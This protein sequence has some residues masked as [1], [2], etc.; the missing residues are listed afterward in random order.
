[1]RES[2]SG[3][4]RRNLVASVLVVVERECDLDAAVERYLSRVSFVMAALPNAAAAAA[5][6]IVFD[7]VVVPP[8]VELAA[9]LPARCLRFDLDDPVAVSR[10]IRLYPRRGISRHYAN[11][12]PI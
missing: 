1:M 12:Q 7:A 10:S 5:A 4:N 2:C 9:S 3:Y 6:I 11:A 8:A